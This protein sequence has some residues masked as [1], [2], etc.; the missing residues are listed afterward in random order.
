[1]ANQIEEI[2]E[3][4]TKLLSESVHKAVMKLDKNFHIYKHGSAKNIE[5]GTDKKGKFIKLYY[6]EMS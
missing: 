3:N 1:M 6:K 2:D 5:A 4:L